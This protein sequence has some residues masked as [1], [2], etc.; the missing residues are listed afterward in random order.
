MQVD[1]SFQ[2]PAKG[3]YRQINAREKAFLF[4]QLFYDVCGYKRDFVHKVAIDPKEIP[5]NTGHGEGD[6][7]PFCVG[8]GIEAVFNPVVG[9]LFAA[10]GAKP[11]LAGMRGLDAF[12]AFWADEHVISQEAGFTHQEFQDIDDNTDSDQLAVFE[13]QLPPVPIIQKYISEFDAANV[14]HEKSIY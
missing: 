8:E 7:L 6:M 11:G 13:E 1:I 2:I 10:G 9:G 5:E 4:C 14:L 3:M 12:V